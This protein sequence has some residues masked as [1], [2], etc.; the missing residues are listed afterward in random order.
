MHGCPSV[1]HSLE[2][3]RGGPKNHS[4]RSRREEQKRGNQERARGWGVDAI[5][6]GAAVAL[7]SCHRQRLQIQQTRAWWEERLPK[8]GGQG[9]R[10]AG[11]GRGG[12]RVDFVE[13]LGCLSAHGC[14]SVVHDLE[15][16]RGGPRNHSERNR[17]E[18]QVQGVRE[19]AKEWEVNSIKN[20]R[21][22]ALIS[23]RR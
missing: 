5:G 18:E 11:G 2:G 19:R 7:A 12:W 22:V 8:W 4:E 6:N 9:H 23:C 13:F 21:A 17:R 3:E 15:G 10:A 16:G 20:G 14:P 1:G